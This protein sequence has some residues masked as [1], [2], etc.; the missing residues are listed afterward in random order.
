MPGTSKIATTMEAARQLFSRRKLYRVKYRGKT[1]FKRESYKELVEVGKGV[2]EVIVA[3]G[4]RP[5]YLIEVCDGVEHGEP[6]PEF[7]V[8]VFYGVLVPKGIVYL[9]EKVTPAVPV[10]K[11]KEAMYD[12]TRIAPLSYH[13]IADEL[14]G[15]NEDQKIQQVKL[16]LMEKARQTVAED[17]ME[18]LRI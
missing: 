17:Y 14:A 16:K 1:V 5:A 6:S 7:L 18:R 13:A 12:I 8:Q 3:V 10:F 4:E 2:F 15:D 11:L 9:G